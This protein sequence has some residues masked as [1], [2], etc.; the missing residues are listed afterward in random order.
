MTAWT[1]ISVYAIIAIALHIPPVQS[2]VGEQVASLLSQKLGTKIVVNR[3]DLGYLNRITIDD[4]EIYDQKGEKM[5]RAGRLSVKLSLIDLLD[6]RISISSAQLFGLN[7]NLYKENAQSEPNFKFVLDSLA[8][9]DTTSHTPL[10]IQISSLVIRNG[11]IKYNQRDIPVTRGV[12]NAGHIAVEKLSSHII[13]YSLTDDNID[14]LLRNMS[15]MESSGFDLRQLKF[16]V[17]GDKHKANLNDFLLKTSNS[18][19]AIPSIAARYKMTNGT[20]EKSSLAVD[21]SVDIRKFSSDDLSF[22]LPD[23]PVKNLEL[24]AN[25]A[26]KEEKGK[27]IINGNLSS[28]DNA[29]SAD[30]NASLSNIFN[31][32][33]VN[34]SKL[35]ADIS[36]AFIKQLSNS[37]SLPSQLVALGNIGVKGSANGS[38][39]NINGKL[40]LSTSNA[41]DANIVASYINKRISADVSTENI[42]LGMITANDALGNIATD[43]HVE[44]DLKDANHPDDIILDGIIKSIFYNNYTYSNI[45]IDG[46]YRKGIFDGS[47]SIDDANASLSIHGNGSINEAKKFINA[48]ADINHFYPQR[49][50]I[51]D[52]WGDSSVSMNA[53]AN[54]SGSDI[55]NIEGTLNITNFNF[56]TTKNTDEGEFENLYIADATLKAEKEKGNRKISFTSDFLDA[57]IQG[58]FNL[59]EI[60]QGLLSI[61]SSH[62]PTLALSDSNNPITNNLTFDTEIKSS[63]WLQTLFDVDIDLQKS[64]S[65]KG[66]VN[67]LNNQTNIFLDMPEASLFGKHVKDLQMLVW[68]PDNSLSS[69]LKLNLLNESKPP[70]SLNLE[71]KAADNTISSLLSWNNNMEDSFRG[72]LNCST[73]LRTTPDRSLS[74]DININPSDI[75]IGDSIWHLHSEQITYSKDF[76]SVKKFALENSNQHIFINGNAS[77]SAQDSL[78]AELKNVN[79]GYILNLVN[80]HSVEFD[81][82]ATGDIVGK[83]LFTSPKAQTHLDV[84]GFTFQEGYMGD[85]HVDAHLN[86]VQKQIDINAYTDDTKGECMYIRGY[87]SPQRNDLDLGIEAKRVPLDFMHYF[88]SAFLKDIDASAHGNVRIFGP[89]STINMTGQVVADGAVTVSSLNCRYTL[90]NDTIRFIP[91][92]IVVNRMPIYDKYGNVAYMSGGLHHKNLARMTYDFDIDARNFLGYD[93]HEF[94]DNTFYGTAFLTGNCKIKGRSSELLI[95]VEGDV[96]KGSRMVYNASSPDA[97]TKREFITWHSQSKNYISDNKIA[98]VDDEKDDVSTNIHMNFLFN[99]TPESSLFLVMDENTG[100]HI[101]LHGSGVLRASYYN[102]GAFDLFG[103]YLIDNGTYK[104]TIQNII[105]RDFEFQK[106]GTISFGGDPYNAALNMQAMYTVNSVPV[107]DLNIGNSFSNNIRVNCLMNISGTPGQPKVDFDMDLPT[108]NTEAKQMIYSLINSEEEMNQQVLYLLSVGRFYSQ[109]G[110]NAGMQDNRQN[111]ATTMAMQSIVSGTI[112]QQINNVLGSVLSTN[113]W[114]FGANISPGNEGFT[115]AEYEGLL[116]GSLFNNR[117]LFNGQFGYRDNATTSQQGFIGD[118]DLRY[119]LVPSGNIS[120]RMY[121]QANDRYFTRN[122]LNTQGLGLI[123]KKDFNTWRELFFNNRKVK[124]KKEK[125]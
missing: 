52:K 115:N 48:S 18:E 114:N 34:I 40:D 81:G 108:V 113:N 103:N 49:V 59:T 55:N 116:N 15:L 61:L 69:T 98:D 71:C 85:L 106:G 79:V 36:S 68:T 37:I 88:C 97:I 117:L 94:G 101:D 45:S 124:V 41:G 26:F 96:E 2:F 119:L 50:N 4:F 29:V 31:N 46:N 27:G 20:I 110:N 21:G 44:A 77:T 72:E 9:K 82:I 22:F 107:S 80:F 111:S 90:K 75:H 35:Q 76:L 93:F 73:R 123:L 89:F 13:L 56:N 62:L 104:M 78:V 12:F 74:A 23:N 33:H 17:V 1:L 47:I 83:Q 122:S 112:S 67:S 42:D 125:K 11:A 25:I 32:P 58:K 70:I 66:F 102:K 63:K 57:N 24:R 121:N 19:I 5:L 60:H 64:V 118:F 95:D 120:V 86:N 100:D 65:V 38:I 105:R 30:I 14:L 3:I 54:L 87:V 16:H 99:I 43:I 84:A 92:D 28:F 8:S 91:D 6:N 7:A 10:D 53:K 39:D 109:T 51:T